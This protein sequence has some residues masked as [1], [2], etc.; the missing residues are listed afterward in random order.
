MITAGGHDPA[1]SMEAYP[2]TDRAPSHA[3]VHAVHRP[4]VRGRRTGSANGAAEIR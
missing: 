3:L 2:M 1:G 4:G